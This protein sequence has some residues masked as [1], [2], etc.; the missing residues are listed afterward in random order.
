MEPEPEGEWAEAVYEYTSDDPG[1]LPLHEGQR[2]LVTERTSDDWW[3]A[4]Y[5][6]RR[7]LVPASY[8]KVL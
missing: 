1:D 5:E 8:I 6:G 4:E 3:T 7:G 2:I